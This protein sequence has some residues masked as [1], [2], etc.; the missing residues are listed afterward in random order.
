[1][2][3][4]ALLRNLRGF[5]E[6]GV[7]DEAAASVAAKL[8]DPAQVARSRQLPM[9]FLSAY[10]AAPSLRWAYPLEVAL[11]HSLANVPALPGR[12]LVLIDTSGSMH[13]GFSRDGTLMRWDAATLFGL[14]LANQC[15]DADVVSFSDSTKVFP[16]RQGESVLA[17]L[18]RWK[19]DGFFLGCG[20]STAKAIRQHFAG[21]D[22]VVVLT[23]EQAAGGSVD[24]AVPATV[25]MITFN[26]AGYRYGHAP[27]GGPNRVTI[28]GLTDQAFRMIPA[29][30]N[31]L[32]GRWPWS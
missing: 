20:T 4:M 23:D 28:G 6:A 15:A 2:G 30:E 29:V 19:Q 25:P 3:Y 5:D 26:L 32:S 9:R 22:R 13:A 27:S 8:S 14:A 17:A 18:Q 21:H 7:D 10:R 1:M 24:T 11:G 16:Q 12:T 31:G